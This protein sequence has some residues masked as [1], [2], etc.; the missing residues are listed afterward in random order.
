MEKQQEILD[1]LD[2]LQ[3]EVGQIK[4]AM[5]SPEIADQIPDDTNPLP[6][7][8]VCADLFKALANEERLKLLNALR[9][10][11]QYFSQLIEIT[12]LAH[13][14]LRFHLMVLKDVNLIG[15]ER[16]RGKYMITELG[17]QSL[18]VAKYFCKMMKGESEKDERE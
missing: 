2:R 13:S 14:P 3:L 7:I 8:S 18:S 1:A 16:F 15:Q 6:D 9:Q 17:T 5:M 11:G 12:S 10:E 4:K